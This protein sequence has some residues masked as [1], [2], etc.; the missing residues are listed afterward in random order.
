MFFCFTNNENETSTR[1][2]KK[3]LIEKKRK[4]KKRIKSWDC[5]EVGLWLEN[6][7]FGDLKSNF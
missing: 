2:E 3:S 5:E 1:E 6:K 4:I 7:G